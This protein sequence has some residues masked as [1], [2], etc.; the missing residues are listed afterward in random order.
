MITIN[1]FLFLLCLLTVCFACNP[2]PTEE[3]EVRSAA[4]YDATASL[5]YTVKMT[6]EHDKEAFTQGLVFHD[7]KVFESTGTEGSW[8]AEVNLENGQQDKKVVLDPQYFGEG[9]TI[10]N[11]KVYQLTWRNKQGFIYDVE[12]F[13]QI[14]HFNYDSEGWGITTDQQYLIMSDGTEKLYYLDTLT[15]RTHKTLSIKEKGLKVEKLNELEYING[16][17]F[18]NQ[19]ETNY[20]LKI[21][22]RTQE[23]VARLDLSSLAAKIKRNYPEA[24]VLNGIAYNPA[25]GDILVTGKRWPRSYLLRLETLME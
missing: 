5:P 17:I 12:S 6:Y 10:L 22:P 20:I 23:V 4:M 24:D 8:I 1:R 18:A 2:G 14:G 9:I 16:Y 15:F 21:D 7:N 11:N 25:T 19:W 3:N 13:R